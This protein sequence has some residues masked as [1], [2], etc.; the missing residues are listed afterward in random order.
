MKNENKNI[1][2]NDLV[3]QAQRLEKKPFDTDVK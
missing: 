1:G 3:N 2:I